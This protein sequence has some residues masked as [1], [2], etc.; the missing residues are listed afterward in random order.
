MSEKAVGIGQYFVTSG[1]PVMLGVPLPIY[2][3]PKFANYL[4]KEIEELY[5]GFWMYDPDPISAA[6]KLIAAIDAKR[7]HLGIDQARDRVLMD[8]ADRQKIEAA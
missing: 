1:V 2:G 5:G 8:M 7:K 6:H 3:S 4:E